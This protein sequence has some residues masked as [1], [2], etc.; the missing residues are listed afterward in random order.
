MKPP[1]DLDSHPV[2]PPSIDVPDDSPIPEDELPKDAHA[3]HKPVHE[4]N[5]D[6]SVRAD[7]SFAPEDSETYNIERIIKERKRK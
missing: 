2:V 3:D 6:Q 7:T 4:S 5:I 1:Y